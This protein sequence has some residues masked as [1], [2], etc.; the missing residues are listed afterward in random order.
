MYANPAINVAMIQSAWSSPW[1]RRGS[2][3]V[4]APQN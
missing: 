2:F 3:E 1:S 4:P